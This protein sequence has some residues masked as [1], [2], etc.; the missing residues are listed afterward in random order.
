MDIGR[1]LTFYMDDERWIEKV[2]IG[3]GVLLVSSLLSVVLIGVLGFFIVMGYTVRLMN[4]VKNDVTPVLP[5]WDQWG[6]DLVRGLK[7]FVVQFVWALPIIL[8][9]IPVVLG[10]AITDNS[11]NAGE[12]VGSMLILCGSCLSFLYGIFVTIVQPGFTVAFAER[13][14]ISDGL[15]VT[16]VWNWTQ[17]RLGD[18][19]VVAIVYLVG[20]II[21]GT[22]GS[23]VGVILCLVGLIVTIP[24]SQ[25]VIYLLQYH[26]YG[27]LAREEGSTAPSAPT[28]PA[29]PVDAPT[30]T[31]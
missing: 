25:M 20:S 17:E 6:D 4:N 27:Q 21:I 26:L 1:A 30:A 7:L 9:I 2:G 11:R 16:K 13:E 31:A 15:Q 10:A 5:E 29:P 24:L 14:D 8:V 28:P 18:V 3:T 19:I 12:F 23:L 22:V